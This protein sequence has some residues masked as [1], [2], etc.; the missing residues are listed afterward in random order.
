M[1]NTIKMAN[2]Q[3][4][5]FSGGCLTAYQAKWENITSDPEIL[6]TI[7][8]HKIKFWTAPVQYNFPGCIP[9]STREAYIIDQEITNLCA[10]GVITSCDREANDFI[11]T[12]FLRPKKDGGHRLILNLS[13]LNE[14]VEYHHFKMESLNDAIRKMTPNCWMCSIDLKDAYYSVP[15]HSTSQK[16]LK[17]RWKNT[18]YKFLTFCNG[19][20]CCPRHFTKILK[21]VFACL[22]EKGH[23]SVV[24]IDDSYL[25]GNSYTSCAK[26]MMTTVDLLSALGFVLHPVKSV[27]FPTQ[28][29][30]FLGFILN[31]ITMSVKLTTDKADKLCACCNKILL[32]THPTIR[33]VCQLIGI[34]VSACPGVMH[35]P[36]FCKQLEIEKIQALKC[37]HGDFDQ[38]MT[39]SNLAKSDIHWWLDNIHT[40]T[41]PIDKG[42]YALLIQSDSSTLGWGAVCQDLEFS[43]GGLWTPHDMGHIN[44]LELK[45]AFLAL[46]SFCNNHKSVHIRLMVDN[47]TAVCYIREMGGSRSPECNKVARDIWLWAKNRNIWLSAAH[48]P[49]KLN[50]SADAESRNFKMETEWML[51]TS[52]FALMCNHFS[53]IDLEIDIFA[54]RINSQLPVYVS[55]RSDPGAKFVDAFTSNWA[56]FTFYAFPPFSLI[57]KVLQ[58]VI[59]DK[60]SGIIVVPKWCTA[61]WWPTVLKL[62]TLPCFY[63]SRGKQI[64]HQPSHPLLIHPLHRKLQL[65]AFHLSGKL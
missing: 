25:Q 64:L 20:S 59:Q 10:K 36:L 8:G 15:V 23:E 47:A 32:Q 7:T 26:N 39:L 40:A 37:N 19:L 50:V 1:Q 52:E 48:I 54:S 61:H 56:D 46:Q 11:S 3:I 4:E 5:F 13:K 9:F 55:W 12:I 34:L 29:L 60:A 62:S 63:F 58:K 21:P 44:V 41:N 30:V 45:A 14:F 6:Q 42:D 65:V 53:F 51:S 31:S 16:Y 35:G 49:G 2:E 17:F 18:Y 22:R 24:Y 43:T 28:I 57:G 27:F 33:D 38:T